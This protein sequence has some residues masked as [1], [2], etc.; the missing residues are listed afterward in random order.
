[1]FTLQIA[2]C[3]TE[4]RIM[5]LLCFVFA[6]DWIRLFMTQGELYQWDS[7]TFTAKRK[8]C[9]ASHTH[10]ARTEERKGNGVK[11]A[12]AEFHTM[13]VHTGR[14]AE[15]NALKAERYE[16]KNDKRQEIEIGRKHYSVPLLTDADFDRLGCV[17][18]VRVRNSVS[19]NHWVAAMKRC[20]GS[21]PIR[22]FYFL[23][24]I[25]GFVCP[26]NQ[27]VTGLINM[28]HGWCFSCVW[29]NQMPS[30]KSNQ[31]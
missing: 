16:S 30:W 10:H 25:Y 24:R 1:M 9:T 6:F 17:C 5:C 14:H 21:A 18:V 19:R 3:A 12:N 7:I 8:E 2:V 28:Q 22:Q 26:Q 31:V 27:F 15:T 23:G 4:M 13:C 20:V 29:P 11:L